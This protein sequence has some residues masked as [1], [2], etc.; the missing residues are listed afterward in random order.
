MGLRL[1]SALG[2][3]AAYIS[4][5]ND[6]V[7]LAVGLDYQ[8]IFDLVEHDWMTQSLKLE[9]VPDRYIWEETEKTTSHLS[10]VLHLSRG[11]ELNNI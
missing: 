5:T 2:N 9:R 7:K 8:K 11:T 6:T 10:T 3:Y 4:Y 1:D